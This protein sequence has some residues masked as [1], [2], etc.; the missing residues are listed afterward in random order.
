MFSGRG[1]SEAFVLWFGPAVKTQTQ[2]KLFQGDGSRQGP[3]PTTER[4][5]TLTLRH[6]LF[7]AK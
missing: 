4:I 1:A 7:G 2:C 5:D 6:C 3:A